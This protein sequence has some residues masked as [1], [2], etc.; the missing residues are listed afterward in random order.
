MAMSKGL[1]GMARAEVELCILARCEASR[2]FYIWG[3]YERARAHFNVAL[4]LESFIENK[5]AHLVGKDIS[6]QDVFAEAVAMFRQ[7]SDEGLS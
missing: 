3:Q 7:M 5:P 4:V 1:G 6:A 2:M